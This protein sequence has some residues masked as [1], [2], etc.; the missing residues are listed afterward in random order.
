[1]I[2][3]FMVVLLLKFP[4]GKTYFPYQDYVAAF[5]FI[6]AAATD[7]LDGYIARKLRQVTNLANSLTRW[8]ISFLFPQL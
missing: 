4:G 7:G 2:P 3:V 6:L 5:I 8:R 1:M